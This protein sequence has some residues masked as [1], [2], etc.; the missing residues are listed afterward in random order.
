[1]IKL[2]IELN[3]K[4]IKMEQNRSMNTMV[5]DICYEKIDHLVFK[6]HQDLRETCQDFAL[7]RLFSLKSLDT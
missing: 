5:K 4:W 6:K 1:M 3:E 7:E 2:H